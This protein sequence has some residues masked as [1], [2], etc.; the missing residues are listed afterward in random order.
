M[1]FDYALIFTFQ[2]QPSMNSTIIAPL[3]LM[4]FPF[5]YNP[6]NNLMFKIY[7]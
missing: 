2:S 5:E 7:E 3:V 4:I 1:K 6:I